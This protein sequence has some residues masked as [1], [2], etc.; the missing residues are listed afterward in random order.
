MRLSFVSLLFVVLQ[1]TSQA[2]DTTTIAKLPEPRANIAVAAPDAN[3]ICAANGL[4]AGKSKADLRASGWCFDKALQTWK[5][6]PSIPG[7]G[8]RLGSSAVT[9]NGRFYLFGGY[10]VA[11]D[12]KET[13]IA[14]L[15]KLSSNRRSWTLVSKHPRP[16][17]DAVLL[18]YRDRW[19]IL[20]SG[21]QTDRNISDVTVFDTQQTKRGWVAL[22]NYPGSAVFGHAGG[23]V[24]DQMVICDGVTARKGADGKNQFSMS[25]Q[26][27]L[28]SLRIGK[29]QKL[30]LTWQ[31]IPAH[32]HLPRYRMAAAGIDHKGSPT[33][34]FAGGSE[35]PYNY[36]GIGYDGI[37]AEASAKV[38]AFD[39][40]QRR[41]QEWP[42]LTKP[43]MDLR[44]LV[45]YQKQLW[46]TGGMTEDQQVLDDLESLTLP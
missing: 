29:N 14:T 43:R 28:G 6:L 30:K 11:A 26:C 32:P 3:T 42:E 44:A 1:N 7:A 39:L 17:D 19:L 21:W 18:P 36:N 20:I 10:E 23:I 34:V 15:H 5:G 27:F 13:T 41:W 40:K 2:L 35:R 33:I 38:F 4:A 46:V 25:N 24:D 12:D 22:A 37:P 16:A 45:S 9:L 8:G 31:A